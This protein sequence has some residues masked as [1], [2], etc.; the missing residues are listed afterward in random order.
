[1]LTKDTEVNSRRHHK[2][3]SRSNSLKIKGVHIE[4]ALV[5]MR[6]VRLKVRSVS[7]PG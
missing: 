2:T 6:G 7:F 1:M 3:K 4:D 5:L